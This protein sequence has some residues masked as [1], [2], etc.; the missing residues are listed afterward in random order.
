MRHLKSYSGTA[1]IATAIAAALLLSACGSKKGSSTTT[2]TT[3]AGGSGASSSAPAATYTACMVTDTGGIDDKSFNAA[4]WQGMQAAQSAGKAKVSYVQSKTETDYATNIKSLQTQKCDLIVT[5]GGL[6]GNATVA[7]AKAA[8]TQHFVEV[9]SAGNGTNLQGLQFNTAQAGFLSGYL[10]AGYSKSGKVATYGGLN[11]PPVTVYMDGFQEGIQ[12]Y[13]TQK[14]KSVSLLGWDETSQKGSFAGS[15]TDQNKGQQLA[16]N[17][18]AQGADVIF[19]VAGG[20]GLGSAAIAKSGGKAVVIWVDTDG[21]VSA[22]QYGSVFLTTAEKNIAQAVQKA[23]EDGSAGTYA[24]TDY[25][26][27][28]ANQGVG[29]ADFHDFASK[30]NSTLQSELKTVAA[31][32]QS[33]KITIKSKSQ[34]K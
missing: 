2:T 33:G 17:F 16:N 20:T 27:T 26:G 5:V 4:A 32:I 34:P 10:A 28:L 15:F 21:F 3:S 19:P 25:I 6:M 23:V 7:A 18:I 12:Y 11:I 8:P 24:T 13:N 30:V 14:G 22:P 1:V 9:D 31:D 29:L